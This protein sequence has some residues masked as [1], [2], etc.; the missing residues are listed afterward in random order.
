MKVK[1]SRGDEALVRD[2][3]DHWKRLRDG[4]HDE[5]EDHSGESCALCNE[6]PGCENDDG[7]TCPLY[8]LQGIPC[9]NRDSVWWEA[10]RAAG[11]WARTDYTTTQ[12][13]VGAQLMIDALTKLVNP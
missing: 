1:L 6:Y 13:K 11:T 12:F 9:D 3:I 2:C 10:H 8:E 7:D 4:K 5:Y